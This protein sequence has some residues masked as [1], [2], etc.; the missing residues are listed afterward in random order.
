MSTVEPITLAIAVFGA[1]LGI[2]NTW[3]NLDKTRVKLVV[4]PKHA[5]PIGAVDPN[6]T[7]CIEVTNLS[8]FAVT[9]SEVGVLY[10]GTAARGAIIQPVLGDGGEWPRRLEPRSSVTVYAHNPAA[11]SAHRIRCAY[12]NTECGVTSRA[13]SPALQQIAQGG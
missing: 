6:L 7:F 5:I 8:S 11:N 4:R 12:A 10:Y 9:I 13:T 2:I 3:H 1:V